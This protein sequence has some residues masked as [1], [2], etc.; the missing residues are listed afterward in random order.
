MS[1]LL[2]EALADAKAVKK[3][4]LL[5]AKAV[6]EETF[7]PNLQRMISAK[8]A[9]EEGDE[10]ELDIDLN[11][12]GEDE[13]EPEMDAPE[14]G[15]G[16]FEDDGE[17]E[18]PPAE[19]DDAELEELLRELDGEDDEM[20]MDEGDGEDDFMVDEMDEFSDDEE[21]VTME[22][23][24]MP[25]DDE[26][27][28]MIVR[29][30]EGEDEEVAPEPTMESRKIRNENA[31]LKKQL[32]EALV[33]VSSLK[34]TI[35]EVNLLNAKLMFNTKVSRQYDLDKKQKTTVLEALDRASNIREVKL[36]YSTIMESLA[37]TSKMQKKTGLKEGYASKS[38]PTIMPKKTEQF[39]F[40]P[41]WQEL[42]NINKK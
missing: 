35:N 24:E 7:Q 28:E 23:D 25:T 9:E 42:A 10:E 30:M 37:K 4:A 31:K 2:K 19:E 27:Y 14:T 34:Q 16:S 18:M 39:N 13:V 36:V 3:T 22:G 26:I 41:R 40:V 11:F 8:L 15:F 17:E 33:V 32:R 12:G 38:T 5:N 1:N 29:E 6:I 21:D 20:S